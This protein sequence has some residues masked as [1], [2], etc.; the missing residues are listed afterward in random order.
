MRAYVPKETER[1]L[2][3]IKQAIGLK[4]NA[5]AFRLM[6]LNSK[7]ARLNKKKIIKTGIL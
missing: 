2:K 5:E 7:I 3:A 6:A 4:S 1:E